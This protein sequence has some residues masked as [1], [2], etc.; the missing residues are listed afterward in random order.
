MWV[1][2]SEAS[3]RA[4]T[5]PEVMANW[6]LGGF[7]LLAGVGALLVALSVPQAALAVRPVEVVPFQGGTRCGTR[8]RQALLNTL[9]HMRRDDIARRILDSTS[10][11]VLATADAAGVPWASPVWF[12]QE[13]YRQFY[14]VSAPN[15]RHSRNIA[16]RPEIA[17]V[18]YDPTV[19]PRS[20][21]AVYMSAT[22]SQTSQGIEV[23]S[24]V[25]VRRGLGEWGPERI[26]G[27]AR[28]RLYR[29]VVT[30]HSILHPAADIDVRVPVSP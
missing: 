23:F 9:C 18:V 2:L 15:A 3:A 1:A 25:S 28:V 13:D 20:A 6:M 27:N 10:F 29:A 22:A 30:E 24:R 12:A 5:C 21:E 14:W 17:M 16:E 26:T 4:G 8:V 11:V 19:T 7:V